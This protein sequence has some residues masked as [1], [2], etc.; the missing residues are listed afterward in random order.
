[1]G[2]AISTNNGK[3]IYCADSFDSSKTRFGFI[4]S[5]TPN[6][7]QKGT[8]KPSKNN[9]SQNAIPKIKRKSTIP[10]TLMIRVF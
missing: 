2:D 5:N 9:K 8:I 4:F 7:I 6:V 10:N 1:M 3:E